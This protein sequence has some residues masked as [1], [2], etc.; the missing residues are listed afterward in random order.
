MI[1]LFVAAAYCQGITDIIKDVTGL[2]TSTPVS[3]SVEKQK[4]RDES[5]DSGV[6]TVSVGTQATLTLEA[7]SL[8]IVEATLSTQATL[9]VKGPIIL[10]LSA[11]TQST[12]N[13][14]AT[15]DGCP[16]IFYSS[17][18]QAS[19]NLQTGSFMSG[20]YA[21]GLTTSA[22]QD[23]VSTGNI[24][25]RGSTVTSPSGE[26]DLLKYTIPEMT[27]EV[28]L[29]LT[30]L[31]TLLEQSGDSELVFVEFSSNLP[32]IIGVVVAVVVIAAAVGGFFLYRSMKKKQNAD[33]PQV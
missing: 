7:K 22:L 29:V 31:A 26:F 19:L 10:V 17:S 4:E 24:Y 13:I 30:S 1:A 33:A 3:I 11:G 21:F 9:T 23:S 27:A 8:S 32:I 15:E 16:L 20:S 12:A 6:Y 5:F 2:L 14:V 28:R 18:T 25:S